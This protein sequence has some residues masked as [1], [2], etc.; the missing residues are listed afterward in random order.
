MAVEAQPIQALIDIDQDF[1]DEDVVAVDVAREG[2]AAVDIDILEGVVE[3]VLASERV[4]RRQGDIAIEVTPAGMPD[5]AAEKV[6]VS[7]PGPAVRFMLPWA[8]APR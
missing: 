3:N 7:Y 2:D 1:P 4:I 5:E 6:R 8:F